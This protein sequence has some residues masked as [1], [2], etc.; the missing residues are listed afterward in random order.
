M[1]IH[2]P[3]CVPV[4]QSHLW[5]LLTL[6]GGEWPASWARGIFTKHRHT[7]AGRN[8]ASPG[9]YKT[10]P[11]NW[12]R[13]SSTNTIGEP[14]PW[15]F[16]PHVGG[17]WFCKTFGEANNLSISSSRTRSVALRRA[18]CFRHDMCLVARLPGWALWAGWWFWVHDWC[19]ICVWKKATSWIIRKWKYWLKND[20][21]S[22]FSFECPMIWYRM[23]PVS[24]RECCATS[25][26]R[27]P[28]PHQGTPSIKSMIV[29]VTL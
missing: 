1:D 25:R 26:Y 21:K 2:L 24:K 23:I 8:P 28:S 6:V 20:P 13:I 15:G 27:F 22:M 9:M 5:H 16:F 4:Y 19:G 14:T 17:P 10:L 18:V 29:C 12:C 7:V 11:T 3:P